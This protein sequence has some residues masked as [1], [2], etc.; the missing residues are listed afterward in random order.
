M[1][2]SKINTNYSDLS[3]GL[4]YE[5]AMLIFNLLTLNGLLYPGLP[6]PMGVDP[7]PPGSLGSAIKLFNDAR[8]KPYYNGQA[9][10]VAAF[11]LAVQNI[12]TENG[13][14]LNTFCNGVLGLLQKTGYNIQKESEAQGKLL[15]TVI[16]LIPGLRQMG[17]SIS[18]LKVRN[19]HYGIMYTL[20]SNPEVD[21]SKWDVFYYAGQRE[22]AILNLKS[23]EK[24]KFASFGMGTD[25]ELT[26]SDTVTATPI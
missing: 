15:A 16:T 7:F 3:E 17:F 24:L 26:Y 22:G 12:L 10:D 5:I 20:E 11:R 14:W 23:G 13:N 4:F 19:V 18:N 25:N 2:K 21:P 1:K 9:G 6:V 8:L